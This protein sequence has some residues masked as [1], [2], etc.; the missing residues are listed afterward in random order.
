MLELLTITANT[1]N[2]QVIVHMVPTGGRGNKGDVCTYEMADGAVGH[3]NTVPGG[4]Q[5]GR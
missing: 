5:K 3:E 2:V 4:V 1:D